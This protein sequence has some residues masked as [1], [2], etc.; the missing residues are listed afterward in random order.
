MHSFVEGV[1]KGDSS[2]CTSQENIWRMR[3]LAVKLRAQISQGDQWP[4]ALATAKALRPFYRQ[5]YPQACH[6]ESLFM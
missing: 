6:Q 5:L 3:L 1:R 4:D 2:L